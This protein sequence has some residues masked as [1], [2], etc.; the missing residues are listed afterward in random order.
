MFEGRRLKKVSPQV[1][2]SNEGMLSDWTTLYSVSFPFQDDVSE[3][4]ERQAE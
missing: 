2:E 1:F 4:K 3:A